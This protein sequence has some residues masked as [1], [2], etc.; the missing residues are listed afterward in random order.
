MPTPLLVRGLSSVSS[1]FFFNRQTRARCVHV[2]F[3]TDNPVFSIAVVSST[4]RRHGRT[5]RS[6]LF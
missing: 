1:V 3:S 4:L 6:R 2:V 5:G